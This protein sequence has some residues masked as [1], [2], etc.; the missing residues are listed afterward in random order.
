MVPA[1]QLLGKPWN[2]CWR[3]KFIFQKRKSD[4]NLLETFQVHCLSSQKFQEEADS[5]VK[6][7]YLGNKGRE[8][9]GF[10]KMFYTRKNMGFSQLDKTK[11]LI[12][13]K[14]VWIFPRV[15]K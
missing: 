9:E 3:E 13:N 7:V 5:E 10:I 4:I 12:P 15:G 11:A 14:N 2:S 6:Q 1:S 8:V